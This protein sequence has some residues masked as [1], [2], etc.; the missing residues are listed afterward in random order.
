[1]PSSTIN[2]YKFVAKMQLVDMQR[3]SPKKSHLPSATKQKILVITRH[4]HTHH[5]SSKKHHLKL[6]TLYNYSLSF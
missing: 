1:M 6:G 2:I 3:L 5:N 4:A